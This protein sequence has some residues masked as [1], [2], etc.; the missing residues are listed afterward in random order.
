MFE[1]LSR[2][3]VYGC[4]ASG[5]GAP[6][7][8]GNPDMIDSVALPRTCPC[9]ENEAG[10]PPLTDPR[11][12]DATAGSATG[13][14]ELVTGVRSNL[15]LIDPLRARGGLCL[16]V[17]WRRSTAGHATGHDTIDRFESMANLKLS[18]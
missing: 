8:A 13:I 2:S 3:N 5:F 9:V 17:A 6:G 15:V 10:S 18:I 16:R 12:V 1:M 7:C 4:D 11:D 14:R